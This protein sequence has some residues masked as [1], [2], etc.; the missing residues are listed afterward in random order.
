MNNYRRAQL[1]LF[2]LGS[3]HAHAYE[4]C[5]SASLNFGPDMTAITGSRSLIGLN[6]A[7]IAWKK[8][9]CRDDVVCGDFRLVLQQL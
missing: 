8:S 2:F 5:D 4:N 7:L 9:D 1:I 3:F 6:Q